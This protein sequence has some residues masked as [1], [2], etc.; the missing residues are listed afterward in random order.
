M[1]HKL[2]RFVDRMLTWGHEYV[3]KGLRFY[4]ER[5]RQQQV[6]LLQKKAAQ[7]FL[8]SRD[9]DVPPIATDD[10]D[11]PATLYLQATADRPWRT[12]NLSRRPSLDAVGAE[13]RPLSAARRRH[14]GARAI[15]A[16]IVN[17]DG[18]TGFTGFA[19]FM[20]FR[21]HTVRK[22]HGVSG[23]GVQGSRAGPPYLNRVN[24]EPGEPREP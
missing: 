10:D 5:H 21:V 17:Q 2:A 9:A 12:I 24:L 11:D 18:F 13:R 16:L 7:G 6:H 23:S 20:G 1:A 8:E 15:G 3:D 4:E 19:R 22:V 14:A